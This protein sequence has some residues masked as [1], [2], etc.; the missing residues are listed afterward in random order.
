VIKSVLIRFQPQFNPKS[1]F[2]FATVVIF[3]TSVNSFSRGFSPRVT[4]Q[5]SLLEKQEKMLKKLRS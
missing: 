4:F 1:I 3:M 2:Q 5:A